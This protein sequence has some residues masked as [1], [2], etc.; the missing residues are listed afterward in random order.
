MRVNPRENPVIGS[1]RDI[2][3]MNRTF[4]AG[5]LVMYSLVDLLVSMPL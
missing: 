3:S 4:Y 2:L 5:K 1:S